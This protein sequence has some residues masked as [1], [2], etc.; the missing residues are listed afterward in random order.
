MVK[1][2]EN[3]IGHTKQL[4][5]GESSNVIN[6][7]ILVLKVLNDFKTNRNLLDKNQ[8]SLDKLQSDLKTLDHLYLSSSKS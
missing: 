1:F 4:T 7:N 5:Y 8:P 6:S 3:S 2:S